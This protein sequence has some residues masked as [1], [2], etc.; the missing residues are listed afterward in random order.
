MIVTHRR[1][2]KTLCILPTARILFLICCLRCA[3]SLGVNARSAIV[4][5]S[6]SSDDVSSNSSSLHTDK[7]ASNISATLSHPADQHKPQ[8]GSIYGLLLAPTN[9]KLHVKASMKF[10]S[11]YGCELELYCRMVMFLFAYFSTAPRLWY[12]SR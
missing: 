8:G 7:T 1:I 5:V 9:G 11:Q 4:R 3:I 10:G 2:W 6:S 12:T